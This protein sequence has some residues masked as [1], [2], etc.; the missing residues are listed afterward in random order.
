MAL[1]YISLPVTKESEGYDRPDLDL[2]EQQ[3]A[4]I[5][6]V[7]AVQPNTVVILNNGAP[8]VMGEWIDRTAAVLEAW[9]MGQAG[10]G[11][12]ADVLY[13]K[14]NPSGKLAET[15]P[16][17]LVDTP[18][19][20]NFPGENGKVRYGEGIFIG[21][22]YYDAKEVPVQFPF[23]HGLSYTK[24]T[25]TNPKVSA[26]TFRDTD[27]VTVSVDVTNS[28]KVVGKEVVQVYVHDHKSAL[29]RPPKELKG[30]IKVEL[31][32]GETKTVSMPLDFRSFAY[33]H[34]G[35]Q[36][37]ITENGEF[38]ILIGASSGDIRCK[39]TVTLES[40]LELPCQLN[41]EST[42]R[43]WIEDS[44]GKSVISPLIS[45][46]DGSNANCFWRRR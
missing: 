15:F 18:A 45:A 16:L 3:I 2:T 1:L 27:G 31:Q 39:Q 5:K 42:L 12:I 24:F 8:V 17:K 46:N 30:F 32:P 33:Y 14:V 37:W 34:P 22:R 43:E 21:Y 13:G 29:V 6:A 35:F 28:G 40:S 20:I 10:G 44:R 4:L 23:G 41:R 9:M 25:Y 36:Q 26:A 11:A 38:D 7:T 19:H